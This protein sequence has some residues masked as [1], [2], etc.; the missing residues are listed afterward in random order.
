MHV[1]EAAGAISA[2]RGSLAPF[3]SFPSNLSE[4]MP[5]TERQAFIGCHIHVVLTDDRYITGGALV[6]VSNIDNASHCIYCFLSLRDVVNPI[7]CLDLDQARGPPHR[8]LQR[9]TP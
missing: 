4:L 6:P 9:L 1:A 2:T 8:P 5:L 7:W 3:S